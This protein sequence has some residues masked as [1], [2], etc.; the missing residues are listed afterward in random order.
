MGTI[1]DRVV[2][3]RHNNAVLGGLDVF[4]FIEI[5]L[6]HGNVMKLVKGKQ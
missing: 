2:I 6:Q 1:C 4:I 3:C 5:G